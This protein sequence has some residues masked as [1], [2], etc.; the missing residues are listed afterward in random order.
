MLQ[1]MSE[2][3]AELDDVPERNPRLWLEFVQTADDGVRGQPA[4]ADELAVQLA[5]IMEIEL[6]Q[7]LSGST[8]VLAH[9]CVAQ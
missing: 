2:P 6:V 3:R 5:V 7:Q 9:P 1:R 8:E 4:G